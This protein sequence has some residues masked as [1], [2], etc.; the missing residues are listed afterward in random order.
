SLTYARPSTSNSKTSGAYCTHRPSPV[1]RSWSIQTSSSSATSV[2]L[3]APL[4]SLRNRCVTKH[5]TRCRTNSHRGCRVILSQKTLRRE[6]SAMAEESSTE[7]GDQRGYAR[8]DPSELAY[9]LELLRAR[10]AE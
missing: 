9:E 7:R 3:D 8:P 10:L 2:N 5:Q 1:H 6:E 4:F